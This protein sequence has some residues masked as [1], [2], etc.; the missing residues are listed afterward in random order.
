MCTDA[1]FTCSS[2]C[3]NRDNDVNP[4]ELPI[5]GYVSPYLLLTTSLLYVLCRKSLAKST[6]IDEAALKRVWANRSD[7]DDYAGQSF[8]HVNPLHNLLLIH[9]SFSLRR[10]EG[11]EGFSTQE[12]CHLSRRYV[13]ICTFPHQCSCYHRNASCLSYTQGFSEG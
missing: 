9:W 3:L 7:D 8:Y 12:T 2:S 5:A 10:R 13:C 4:F 6:K 11:Q 1:K